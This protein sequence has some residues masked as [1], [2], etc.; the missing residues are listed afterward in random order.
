MFRLWPENM[1]EFTNA[2]MAD[3]HLVYGAI[4]GN[5]RTVT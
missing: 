4:D 5:G 1:E 3:I 2:E